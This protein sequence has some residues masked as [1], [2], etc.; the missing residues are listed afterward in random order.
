MAAGRSSARRAVLGGVV[1]LLVLLAVVLPDLVN[2][3]RLFLATLIVIFAVAGTGLVVIM[4]WTG[5]IALAHVS[6]LGIG[7]YVTNWLFS[8]V[9]VPWPLA[10]VLAACLASLIGVMIGF[11]AARLR[12]FYLAI[13]TLAFAE[14]IS[15]L[16]VEVDV[17]TGGIA[18]TSIENVQL[19]GLSS[20]RSHW[21][22]AL[23]VAVLVFVG[24]HQLGRTAFGRCLRTV[25]DAEVATGSL[26]ISST[27]YKLFAFA[28]SA[29]IAALAGGLF[30]QLLSY[31]SPDNFHTALLI[32]FLV[33]VFVGG[34]TRLS[35]TVVGAIFVIVSRELL[36]D[37]GDWQ[38]WVFGISLVLAVRFLPGGLT[39]I[40]GRIRSRR[41]VE[42]SGSGV[43]GEGVPA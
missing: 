11:P 26:G 37:V 2:P 7:V 8:D 29:F 3:Y 40:G 23:I 16:F 22:M 39:S 14:L 24:V 15:R 34:V 32:Q 20:A 30:G 4:G 41:S 13:A 27:N 9:G 43:L 31:A 12:G 42:S 17:V 5:Q 35:G 18:G 6:F 10:L 38:R 36:Q 19:F 1:P 21:Y 28:L 33:V 25:R